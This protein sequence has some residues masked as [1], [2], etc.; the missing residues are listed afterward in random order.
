MLLL[1]A[2][3]EFD[4]CNPRILRCLFFF[5]REVKQHIETGEVLVIVDSGLGLLLLEDVYFA[6]SLYEVVY[7]FLFLLTKLDFRNGVLPAM[8]F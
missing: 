4:V 5:L 7:E 3:V 8:P 1:S 6:Y 2:I